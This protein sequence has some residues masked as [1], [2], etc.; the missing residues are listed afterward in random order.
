[1]AG[2]WMLLLLRRNLG[3]LGI[4]WLLAQLLR[5]TKELNW[6]RSSIGKELVRESNRDTSV[7]LGFAP[8]KLSRSIG[9]EKVP[10]RSVKFWMWLWLIHDLGA[11][12]KIR[13]FHG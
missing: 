4:C 8:D 3:I 9:I 11:L 5:T 7:T 13:D 1:M 6:E 2:C 10:S 12:A